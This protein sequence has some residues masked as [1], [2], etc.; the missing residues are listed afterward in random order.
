M[1]IDVSVANESVILLERLVE[2]ER[3]KVEEMGYRGCGKGHYTLS[4]GFHPSPTT[5]AFS[6][7]SISDVSDTIVFRFNMMA[8]FGEIIKFQKND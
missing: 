3:D 2:S 5:L 1:S 4:P 7:F 6:D 8:Q